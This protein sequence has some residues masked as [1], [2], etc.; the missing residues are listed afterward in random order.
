MDSVLTWRMG[1]HNS[2]QCTNMED[3]GGG[4]NSGQCT[5]M[6]DGGA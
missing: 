6:E 5:N 4:H 1:G 2:G 3:G